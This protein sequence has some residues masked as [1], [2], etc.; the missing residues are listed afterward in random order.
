M[1]KWHVKELS[2]LTKVSVQ[3]LHYYDR[4]DLLKP[5]FRQSNGYRLYIQKDVLKLQNIIALKFFGF[6]LKQIKNLLTVPNSFFEDFLHQA[7]IL[8][9]KSRSLLEASKALKT[10]V[11]D[12]LKSTAPSWETLI[13]LIEVYTMT[14]NIDNAWVRKVLNTD[15]LHQYATFEAELHAKSTPETKETFD[16]KWKALVNQIQESLVTDPRS[17][18]G[19]NLAKQVLD[20]I[21]GLYGE[22][23]ANLKHVLWKKGFKEGKQGANHFLTPERVQWLD[24]AMDAYLKHRIYTLLEKINDNPNPALEKEWR[25]LLKEMYGTSSCLKDRLVQKR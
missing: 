1:S 12:S 19:M 2:S 7:D 22:K 15:E 6:S 23:H 8:E 11:T 5:S 24:L 10:I 21:N 13:K 25:S 17:H 18:E 14:Q 20:L 4:I 3:T 16:H 9:D